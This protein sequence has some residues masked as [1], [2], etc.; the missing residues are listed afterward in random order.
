[1][2]TLFSVLI[3]ASS[4]SLIISVVLQEGSEAGM[5]AIAGN[6]SDSLWGKSKGTSRG[7][8]LKRIT[9]VSAVIFIIS[10]L[11]LAAK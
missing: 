10:A 8:M 7:A 4:L 9:V 2:T 1:M 5:G 3:L 6:A 11:V